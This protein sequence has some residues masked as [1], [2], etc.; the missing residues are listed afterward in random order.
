M[1]KL[2]RFDPLDDLF[3]GFFVRPVDM[4]T[5]ANMPSIKMDVSE[6]PK[7]FVVHAELPGVKKDDIHV[8]IEGN[9]VSITAEVK[10]ER[11][12]KDDERILRAER[13]FGQIS[14]TFQLAQD[15]DDS[16]SIAKFNEGV[17]ELTL[18]K[19]AASAS[20]RLMIE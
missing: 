12:V 13:F 6:Q 4:N 10:Q 14:R 9:Q 18:P 7:A 5:P 16:Q 15:I 2:T 19:K 1:N 17:L 8:Q 3:R 20:K 11:E